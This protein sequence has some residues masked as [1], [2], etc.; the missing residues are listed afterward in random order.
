MSMETSL[1]QLSVDHGKHQYN[2]MDTILGWDKKG[3]DLARSITSGSIIHGACFRNKILIFNW[4]MIDL[5]KRKNSSYGRWRGRNG[6]IVNKWI[7]V[8]II[9]SRFI[10]IMESISHKKNG[11]SLGTVNKLGASDKIKRWCGLGSPSV[12]VDTV[13]AVEKMNAQWGNDG[14]FWIGWTPLEGEGTYLLGVKL[15][16]K[17]SCILFETPF[18]LT[19][20]SSTSSEISYISSWGWVHWSLSK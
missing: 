9:E 15:N 17:Q 1:S 19:F 11:S 14:G 12:V 6:S 2:K 5:Q 10:V 16:I 7:N 3:A 4:E 13:G 18:V 20:I 8:R